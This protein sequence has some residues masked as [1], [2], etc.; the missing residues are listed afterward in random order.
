MTTHVKSSV[1]S[2]ICMAN[3]TCFSIQLIFTL[4]NYYRQ[5]IQLIYKQC[6]SFRF[7]YFLL[8]Y[9]V[10]ICYT[11]NV[12]KIV[13][14][15]TVLHVHNTWRVSHDDVSDY[16]MLSVETVSSF[17]AIKSCFKQSYDKYG[18]LKFKWKLWNDQ[19]CIYFMN[20]Q[21]ELWAI[22]KH[23]YTYQSSPIATAVYT[24]ISRKLTEH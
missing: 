1:Y 16:V 12:I 15:H 21:I 5:H 3:G 13:W 6:Y 17:M 22:T 20:S 10:V 9:D 4:S 7:L 24:L 11:N 23:Y 14:P 2:D 8:S 19:S 18:H